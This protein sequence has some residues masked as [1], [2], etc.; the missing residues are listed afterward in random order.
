MAAT[1]NR[2]D[3]VVEETVV[4]F[5]DDTA[6]AMSLTRP[7]EF[8]RLFDRHY[9]AVWR[10]LCRRVGLTAAD[11]IAGETF[12]RAFSRRASYRPSQLGARPWLYGIATNLIR[13]YARQESRQL[14][15]YARA[16][17]PDVTEDAFQDAD[18][19]LDA[20]ALALA[21][22]TALMSLSQPDRDALL[23]LALTE[24]DYA[25]IAVALG[26]RVGTVRSRLH[27]RAAAGAARA[28]HRP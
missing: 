25:G 7:A 22:I 2:E 6:V 3:P 10:Y 21:V 16:A 23:L 13:E 19:R 18:A 1:E 9:S 5:D 26:V 11:D 12:L 20:A 17:E 28:G 4:V 27:P 15:A 8:A 14:R 24:L